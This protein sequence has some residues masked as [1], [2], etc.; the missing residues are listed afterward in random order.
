MILAQ[1]LTILRDL[2]WGVHKWL[3]IYD[4]LSKLVIL[5][6]GLLD[7]ICSGCMVHLEQVLL[8]GSQNGCLLFLQ[9]FSLLFCLS[10]Q[11]S[12]RGRKIV[13][14]WS[15]SNLDRCALVLL[16]WNGDLLLLNDTSYIDDRRSISFWQ[17]T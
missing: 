1:I 14:V 13:N 17:C 2:L 4:I 6:L 8:G 16:V 12:L 7:C 11:S 5:L 3:L 15:Q 10:V 9:L